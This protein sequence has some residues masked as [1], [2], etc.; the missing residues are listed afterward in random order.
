[1]QITHNKASRAMPDFR[2]PARVKPGL[3]QKSSRVA[4]ILAQTRLRISSKVVCQA[5]GYA[6]KRISGNVTNV[7]TLFFAERRESALRMYPSAVRGIQQRQ[8]RISASNCE[9]E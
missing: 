5:Q 3:D 2:A 8:H 9:G 6:N 1:M 7:I 4:A